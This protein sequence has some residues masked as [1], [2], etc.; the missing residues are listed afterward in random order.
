MRALRWKKQGPLLR[1]RCLRGECMITI[2]LDAT[3]NIAKADGH[4]EFS[5]YGTD[6]VCAGVSSL[7]CSYA[8]SAKGAKI[9]KRAGHMKICGKKDTNTS[10]KFDMLSSGLAALAIQYPQNIKLFFRGDNFADDF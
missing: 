4:A 2:Y 1:V 8:A 5:S 9:E 10:A 7:M 3:N 6:I